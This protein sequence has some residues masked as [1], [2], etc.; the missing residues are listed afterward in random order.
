LTWNSHKIHYDNHYATEIEG[1]PGILVH[2][3][4]TSCLL[5]DLLNEHLAANQKQ[6]E[7]RSLA[8]W[9]YTAMSPLFVTRNKELDA[10][11]L[12]AK[13]YTAKQSGDTNSSRFHL[14][15]SRSQNN[16]ITMKGTATLLPL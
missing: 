7:N 16:T 12:K 9:Q 6:F 5:I 2:G 3:P 13:L 4:L 11:D 15:S 14:W 8:S 1:Y 10:F